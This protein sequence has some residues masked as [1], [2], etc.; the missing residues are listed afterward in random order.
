M[1]SVL[2]VL[3]GARIWTL[4]DGTAHPTGY[5][6][7][8]FVRPHQFFTAAGWDVTVATPAGRTP[9][10]DELSLTLGYNNDDAG[11]VAF[12]RAY[13]KEHEGL[14][15]STLPLEKADA[16]SYDVLF[17]VGGHG[18]MQDL[19]VDP[20]I[21]PLMDSMLDDPKKVVS[22]VCH[23]PASMLSAARPDGTWLFQGRKMTGFTNEEETQA[24]FAGSAVWLLED[25]LRRAGA[26]FSSVP[27]WGVHVVVDGNL[28]T[29]QNWAS[30]VPAAEAI[31]KQI[32]AAA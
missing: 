5:W 15:G 1:P 17:A 21:G 12:Q 11:E 4:K 30:A 31:L 13:I 16:A 19:A 9:I 20:S 6:A 10:A 25:R 24:T 28:V 26:V 8:E 18:P 27:A 23:G 7:E 2:M 14:L 22:A 29:G 32:K 3:S